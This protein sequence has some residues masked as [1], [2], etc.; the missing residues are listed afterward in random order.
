MP[1]ETV[2]PLVGG[3]RC[4]NNKGGFHFSRKDPEVPTKSLAMNPIVEVDQAK[5]IA[6]VKICAFLFA[7][8]R[9]ELFL[10]VAW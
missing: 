3:N 2:V 10:V 5:D 4:N 7:I 1:H 9:L 6:E 8:T